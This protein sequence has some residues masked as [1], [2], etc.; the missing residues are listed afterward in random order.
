MKRTALGFLLFFVIF[1]SS[2]GCTFVPTTAEGLG[3]ITFELYDSEGSLVATKE[4]A[5]HD[6]DTLFS[7]LQNEFTVTYD[8]YSFGVMITGIDDVKTDDGNGYIAFYINDI[9]A[10]TG[11]DSAEIVDGNIYQ[12]KYATFTY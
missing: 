6:G 7:L 3:Q 11:I 1:L 8:Q 4:V 2:F 10:T 9:E 12:F 5:Y